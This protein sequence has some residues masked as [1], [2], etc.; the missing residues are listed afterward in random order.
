MVSLFFMS[1]F[2][3]FSLAIF[4][5]FFSC[6]SDKILET[7]IDPILT[8]SSEVFQLNP[9]KI[10]YNH[11]SSCVGFLRDEDS[12]YNN[13]ILPNNK[14]NFLNSAFYRNNLLH[15]ENTR[16]SIFIFNS[17]KSNSYKYI[18]DVLYSSTEQDIFLALGSDDG[19][20]VFNNSNLIFKNHIGR[21]L[22][23]KNDIIRIHL[24]K[25][26]NIIS[27]KVDQGDGA[28]SLYRKYFPSSKTEYLKYFIKFN[29]HKYMTDPLS[30]YIITDNFLHFNLPQNATLFD[31]G[32][33]LRLFDSSD[34][35]LLDT[36]V[37]TRYL[38]QIRYNNQ[39]IILQIDVLDNST[40]FFSLSYPVLS[41]I[42]LD[43]IKTYLSNYNSSNDTA[44]FNLLK[45][46]KSNYYSSFY[47]AMLFISKYQEINNKRNPFPIT[48]SFVDPIDSSYQ[49]Y[50]YYNMGSGKV[51]FCIHGFYE[52]DSDFL[53]SYEGKSNDIL[54]RRF[55]LAHNYNT[56]IIM[57]NGR[58]N[59]NFM[60]PSGESEIE[61]ILNKENLAGSN[62]SLITYSKGF[63]SILKILSYSNITPKSVLIAGPL[64]E[65]RDLNNI[66]GYINIIKSKN[67]NM[68]WIIVI[69]ENDLRIDKELIDKFVS[70]LKSYNFD[71]K[72]IIEKYSDHFNYLI[73][74]EEILLSNE[75]NN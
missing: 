64:F 16:D 61:N 15:I 59:K 24:N 29:F 57:S 22:K 8:F 54:A 60:G 11:D 52:T 40:N 20:K 33:R 9:N 56:G 67:K 13:I 3:F 25:G 51:I 7:S 55:S 71:V 47:N 30:E 44:F 28:W 26:Y 37:T 17:N 58:G 12:F 2:T 72:F 36:L 63:Q 50:R 70:L 41:P 6:N 73:D 4:P 66:E 32:I 75:L 19:I 65:N 68:K 74:P 48:T 46:Y 5:F 53:N 31:F 62:Y 1:N 21:A 18:T 45:G 38:K 49:F 14:D 39:G 23:L 34:S 10:D 69:G 43:S 27:M 35:V 42:K